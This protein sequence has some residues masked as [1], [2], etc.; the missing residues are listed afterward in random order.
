MHTMISFIITSI[1]NGSGVLL[2]QIIVIYQMIVRQHPRLKVKILKTYMNDLV[3]KYL[4]IELFKQIK[5]GDTE[6]REWLRDKL[7]EFFN[8]SMSLYKLTKEDFEL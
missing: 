3:L 6:H 5:H 1:L 8:A 2:V 7:I 4:A